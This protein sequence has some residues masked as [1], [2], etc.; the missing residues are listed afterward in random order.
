MGYL[1]QKVYSDALSECIRD[2]KNCHRLIYLLLKWIFLEIDQKW[3]P[4]KNDLEHGR[5]F[6]YL[7]HG[8]LNSLI[9]RLESKSWD[10]I[11]QHFF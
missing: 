8:F 5:P 7:E 9:T 11:C 10:F 3:E 1:F 4:A 6:Q 2:V